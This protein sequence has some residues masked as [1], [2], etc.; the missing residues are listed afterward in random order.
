L[1]GSQVSSEKIKMTGFHYKFAN[2]REALRD[3][4]K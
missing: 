2:L 3:L 4:L 1:N